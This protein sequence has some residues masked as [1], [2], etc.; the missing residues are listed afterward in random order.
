MWKLAPGLAALTLL[1]APAP[2]GAAGHTPRDCANTGRSLT[3]GA[4]VRVYERNQSV[5]ACSLENGRRIYLGENYTG[6]HFAFVRPVAVS[7]R[8]VAWQSH[9]CSVEDRSCDDQEL[10]IANVHSGKRR[11]KRRLAYPGA[12]E[13]VL[14]PNGSAAWIEQSYPDG[15]TGVR[16]LWRRDS[17]GEAVLARGTDLAGLALSARPTLYWTEGG[18]PH[19]APLEAGGPGKPYK[20]RRPRCGDPA[21]T[22]GANPWVRVWTDD[23]ASYV[24]CSTETGR[25]TYL[26]ETSASAGGE[27]SIDVFDP[28]G[29][30]V[31]SYRRFCIFSL[32]S[33]SPADS[34]SSC[35]E[36]DV[37]VTDVRT[38]VRRTLAEVPDEFI[39]G[40]LLLKRNAS[41]AFLQSSG[42]RI[43]DRGGD[44]VVGT[45]GE[46]A[47]S[48][49]S[50]V[51]W[52]NTAGLAQSAPI[53]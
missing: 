31:P 51:Y 20:E 27:E 47:M 53:D 13:M 39:V 34:H 23:G 49:S 29:R 50:I 35:E 26:G 25:V 33:A 28:A 7:G 22:V 17:S 48:K 19:S 30:L 4:H 3:G 37:H 36:N 6:R 24:A 11:L 1:A 14:R 21:Y 43:V 42:V 52:T 12:V 2:A 5:Y 10:G 15:T 45:G 38:G 46:L 18:A 40:S 32:P 16:T 9:Y 44:R 8:L 41:V